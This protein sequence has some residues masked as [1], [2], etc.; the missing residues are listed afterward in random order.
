MKFVTIRD[1]RNKTAEIRKEL[2]TEHEMVLTANGHPFAILADVAD[3]S[4]EETLK[5]LR[6]TR[7]R[8]LLDRAGARSQALGLDKL[9][10]D[11]IDGIIAK[12]RRERR[13][14]K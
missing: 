12:T 1:F 2:K 11:E 13:A 3:D 9:T 4:F 14:A 7:A 6:S 5:A 10:M 8:M